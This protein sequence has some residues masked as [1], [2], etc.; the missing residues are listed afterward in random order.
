[1]GEIEILQ[2]LA[3]RLQHMAVR[4][5]PARAHAE[6]AL[7][8]NEYL[9]RASDI[10]MTR[11]ALARAADIAGDKAAA[12]RQIGLLGEERMGEISLQAQQA[13]DELLAEHSREAA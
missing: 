1:M 3:Q 12:E 5:M 7:T 13:L 8:I 10:A 2:A 6:E 9:Q 4:T 11:V